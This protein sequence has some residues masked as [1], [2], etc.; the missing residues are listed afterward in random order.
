M[1]KARV[2]G[3]P[4]LEEGE[5]VFVVW[6]DERMAGSELVRVTTPAR[7]VILVS[8]E[9]HSKEVTAAAR[10]E[11]IRWIDMQKRF[12]DRLYSKLDSDQPRPPLRSHLRPKAIAAPEARSFPSSSFR[13]GTDPDCAL[14]EGSGQSEKF[15]DRRREPA[16]WS[17]VPRVGP[18]PMRERGMFVP[19]PACHQPEYEDIVGRSVPPYTLASELERVEAIVIGRTAA[20]RQKANSSRRSR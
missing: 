3:I 13:I 14:C 9:G 12:M 8:P 4:Q 15:M 18:T 1:I 16:R 11:V 7:D 17:F 5:I 6:V 20:I 2:L 19:C 10:D